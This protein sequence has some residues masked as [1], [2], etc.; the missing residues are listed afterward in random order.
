MGIINTMLMAVME[1]TR[2]IGMMAALGMKKS[3]I[4]KLFIFEG[5][6]IGVFGSLLG[7]LLG[8]LA[9]WYLEVEGWSMSFLARSPDMKRIMESVYPVKDLYYADLTFNTLLMTFLFGTAIAILASMYPAR[10]AAK[11]NPIQALRHI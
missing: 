5:G 3:E 8:G 11:M 1:R 6:F 4:M 7:C 10:K 9:S 2:E